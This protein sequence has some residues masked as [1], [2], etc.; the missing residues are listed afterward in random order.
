MLPQQ[1][2][3]T[4]TTAA[5]QNTGQKMVNATVGAFEHGKNVMQQPTSGNILN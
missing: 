4:T 5:G 3:A 2:L 1:N